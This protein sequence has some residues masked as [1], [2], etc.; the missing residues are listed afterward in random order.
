MLIRHNEDDLDKVFRQKLYNVEEEAPLHLWEGIRQNKPKRRAFI[1]WWMLPVALLLSGVLVYALRED[2]ET[3]AT[4]AQ[5]LNEKKNQSD[6][7]KNSSSPTTGAKED[8]NKLTEDKNQTTSAQNNDSKSKALYNHNTSNNTDQ[9]NTISKSKN[10]SSS[11][12]QEHL[13]AAVNKVLVKENTIGITPKIGLGVAQQK[14]VIDSDVFPDIF[15]LQINDELRLDSLHAHQNSVTEVMKQELEAEVF[16][17]GLPYVESTKAIKPHLW[18]IG[19]YY[20]LSQPM[21]VQ[22]PNANDDSFKAFTDRTSLGLS[23]GFGL[24]T[25]YSLPWNVQ[26]SAGIEYQRFDERH[27]WIDSTI[28]QKKTFVFEYDTLIAMDFT[29]VTQNIAD[30]VVSEQLV[31]N[32]RER[33][34]R[35]SS[36][37]IPVLLSWNYRMDKYSIGLELGPV[38]KINSIYT[39]TFVFSDWVNL[40]TE[41]GVW[42]TAGSI[43]NTSVSRPYDLATVQVY[44]NWRTDLHIGVHQSYMITPKLSASLALQTRIMMNDAR[45]SGEIAHRFI[46]PGVRVGLNYFIK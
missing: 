36:I 37:N 26:V 42:N 19:A 22:R 35:Y 24:M 30:S 20:L 4:M 18:S 32:P 31:I 46:Q 43:S 8:D 38:F 39:G 3:Q 7:R 28:V 9:T 45:T 33:V 14:T 5:T 16:S 41:T 12:A 40:P 17:D 2:S 15:S 27:Q 21:R 11:I 10:T 1:W 23:H 44:R 13:P 25:S 6:E 29:T 34:N